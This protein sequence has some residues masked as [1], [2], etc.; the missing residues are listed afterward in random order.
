MVVDKRLDRVDRGIN[1]ARTHQRGQRPGEPAGD[2]PER[3]QNAALGR[4]AT[5]LLAAC[6]SGIFPSFFP[7]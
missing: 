4:G 7:G 2:T 1:G 3:Q 6:R 5:A